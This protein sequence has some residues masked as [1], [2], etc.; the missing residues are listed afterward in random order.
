MFRKRSLRENINFSF[1]L[2]IKYK[3]YRFEY[4]GEI[5]NDKGEHFKNYDL[6]PILKK[7][8]SSIGSLYHP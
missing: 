2:F 3:F 8:E 7:I 1:N 4:R 5:I 6:H